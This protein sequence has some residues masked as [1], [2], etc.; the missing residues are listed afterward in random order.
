MP[1]PRGILAFWGTLTAEH[2]AE[3]ED[4]Y[5]RQHLIERM[6]VTGF[7]TGQRYR[8]GNRF[9]AWYETEAPEVLASRAYLAR[10]A[11]PT[12]WTRRVMPWVRRPVRTVFVS[13]AELGCGRG[14][15]AAV[16]DGWPPLAV[17]KPLI[18]EPGMLAIRRWQPV[19]QVRDTTESRLRRGGDRRAGPT[20]LVEAT[21]I[22][23]LKAAL[24]RPKIKAQYYTLRFALG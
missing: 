1:Q 12:A 6:A 24:S 21:D 13:D 20:T 22:A 10:L 5:N 4:W 17:L 8:N 3:F 14:A 19:E 9:F 15:A 18:K 2:A 23:S 11:K 16:I 7:L